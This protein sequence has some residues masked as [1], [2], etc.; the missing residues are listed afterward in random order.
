MGLTN[1]ALKYANLAFKL[2]Y[3][4]PS[5][6]FLLALLHYESNP[7]MAMYHLKNVL[8][9][10]PDYYDGQAEVLLKIWACRA[11]LG[12]YNPIKPIDK[13]QQEEIC[14]GSNKETFKGQGMICSANGDNCKTA[15][16][17]CFHAKNFDGGLSILLLIVY[18][19]C[20]FIFRFF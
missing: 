17:Q 2:N 3:V 9:V 8:R 11:K 12:P 5:T 14:S 20:L 4:E 18:Y 16:I 13:G 10:D 19:Y 7:L 15:S 1:Q 6:N